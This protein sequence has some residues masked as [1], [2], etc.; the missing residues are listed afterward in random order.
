MSDL[1]QKGFKK[2]WHLVPPRLITPDNIQY[3]LFQ[4]F[5]KID[6]FTSPSPV[7]QLQQNISPN[8]PKEIFPQKPLILAGTCL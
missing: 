3:R 5:L 1:F 2:S 6:N 7:C 4:R 8:F